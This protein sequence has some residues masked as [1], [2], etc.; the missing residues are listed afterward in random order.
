VFA[1]LLLIGRRFMLDSRFGDPQTY[2]HVK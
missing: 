2:L 1:V